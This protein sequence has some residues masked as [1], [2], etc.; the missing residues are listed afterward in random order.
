MYLF[1]GATFYTD[2]KLAFGDVVLSG[3]TVSLKASPTTLQSDCNTVDA[4][5]MLIIPGFLDVHVHL[6]EPG[7]FYKESM[8]TGTLAGAS[9]GY[10]AL[11]AMP[12]LNPVPDSLGKLAVEEE[13][14]L[15]DAKIRVYPYG[16][17]TVDEKGQKLSDMENIAKRVA[18]FSDDGTGLNDRSLM[19]EAMLRAKALD[20][21]IAAHCEDLQLR[22]GGYIHDGQ[23]AKRHNHKGICSESEWKPI[24]QDLPK[25]RAARITSATF[26]QKK[27]F[28]LYATQRG[29]ACGSRVKPRPTILRFAMRI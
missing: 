18:A 10:T 17:L 8:A 7:F 22:A 6:R 23:Y 15:K 26:R 1:K 28:S 19:R 11:C 29:T 21:I 25:K 20:K 9:A 24:E 16:A 27:A 2:G 4:S 5:E 13:A 14:I 12:N 3:D